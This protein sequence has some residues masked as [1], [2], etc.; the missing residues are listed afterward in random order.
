MASAFW[1]SLA[2]SELEEILRYIREEGQRPETSRRLGV[3]IRDAADEHVRRR[4]PGS[5]HHALPEGWLYL[6]YK[7]WLITYV[8]I[9]D[10]IVIQRIVDATRDLPEQ[11][12]SE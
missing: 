11:F 4:L 5:R 6:K 1:T 7:R 2:E 3:E 12:A 8:S 9:G 10:D